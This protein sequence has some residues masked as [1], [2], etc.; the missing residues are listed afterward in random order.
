VEG[1]IPAEERHN[2]G[3]YFTNPDIVD[4]ILA[5]SLKEEN[6]LVFDPGCGAGTFL[7]RAYHWKKLQNS[8][9]THEDILP[10]LWGND[11]DK[12][13]VGLATI[14]LAIADLRSAENYPR[15]IQK[16]FFAWQ[17]GAVEISEQKRKVFLQGLGKENKETVIPKYFDAIVGNPPYTRQE[18]MDNLAGKGEEYKDNLIKAA[19]L[20]EGGRSYARLSKRAGLYAYFFVHGTK[21]LKQGGRFGFIVSNSWLDADYGKGLQE[22]FLKHYK[23]KAIIESK[24]E[25]W[26]SEADINTCLVLLE[27][28]EGENNGPKKERE[29]N[30]VRFVTLKK[31][32]SSFIPKASRIF[33]ETV[34]RKAVVEK[35]WQNIFS[36]TSVFENDDLRVFAKNQKELLEEGWDEEKKEYIGS[37]WEK[38]LRAPEIYFK[39]LEKAKDKLIPLKEVADVRFG[40]KT[41]ANEFFYLTEEEIK[42]REIEEEFW[43]HQDENGQWIPN[44]V[45]KSPKECRTITVKP[46]DLQYRVLLIHKDRDQLRG[47]RIL[48]YI[49][50]GE[51]QG[52]NERPTCASRKNW[53]DL[54]EIFPLGFLYPMIHNDRQA[55]FANLAEVFV[56][57]NLFEVKPKNKED[58]ESLCLFCASSLSILFRELGGRVN[59]GEGALK[60]EGMDLERMPVINPLQLDAR[61]KKLLHQWFIKNNNW[62]IKSIF[63]EVIEDE[64][65]EIKVEEKRRSLDLIIMKDILDLEEDEIT[66]VYREVLRLVKN[67]L[68]RAE[69]TDRKNITPQGID[70]KLL[71]KTIIDKVGT[72]KLGKFYQNKVLGCEILKKVV[73]PDFEIVPKINQTLM[74]FRLEGGKE[75]LDFESEEEAEYCLVFWQAGYREVELVDRETI[76]KI[77]PELKKIIDEVKEIILY[78]TEGVLDN[79][80]IGQVE[81]LVWQEVS[82]IG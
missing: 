68:N 74:G 65:K 26:F 6:D 36:K 17:P 4:L 30:L 22:H 71:A 19:V 69:S 2:L 72:G 39:I 16:D 34:E 55:I 32:L 23:I 58:F 49:R 11:I 33:E 3:Q 10:T 80:V 50:E 70:L 15:V 67:R 59:L 18:E 54:G 51:S 64:N 20:D 78:Y 76:K 14:N 61:Q 31:P 44:Y 1:L 57:H 66:F 41:G 40:I 35:F 60:T 37:K 47:K 56:D 28:C 62:E 27:K 77:L 12:F 52:Y 45:I 13:A 73:F 81:H 63:T 53:W 7:R 82:K 38:F 9:L 25:R 5:F 79:K 24:V 42:R 8:F 29:E 21:F 48:D 43:M 75:G 46:E